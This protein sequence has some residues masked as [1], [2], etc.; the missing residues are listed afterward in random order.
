MTHTP[1]Q[2][3]IQNANDDFTRYEESNPMST[4][5]PNSM[6]REEQ[7]TFVRDLTANILASVEYQIREGKIPPTWDGLELRLLLEYRFKQSANL[8]KRNRG[9]VREF[10]HTV[11]V[12]NL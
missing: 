1:G 7:I 10:N 6:T 12:N 11:I 3:R 4:A 2:W 5:H 8:T 9:L